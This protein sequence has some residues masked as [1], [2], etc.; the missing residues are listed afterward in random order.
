MLENEMSVGALTYP[1]GSR[2]PHTSWGCAHPRE[3]PEKDPS[4]PL[5]LTLSSVQASS[6]S[7]EW[8]NL[9]C[10]TGSIFNN[11][12]V[13]QSAVW[14]QE[15]TL[16]FLSFSISLLDWNC[17]YGD[18][19]VCRWKDVCS[20]GNMHV[21]V[22]GLQTPH[23]SEIVCKMFTCICVFLHKGSNVFIR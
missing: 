17:T 20:W 22:H 2:R 19:C 13:T 14:P 6:T 18:L 5:G 16:A 7:Q 4:S 1:W 3:R 9:G 11:Q 23:G 8:Q 15:V 21:A 12:S 10:K